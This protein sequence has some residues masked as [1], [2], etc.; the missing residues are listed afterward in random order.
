MHDDAN[1]GV[2]LQ[3]IDPAYEDIGDPSSHA[4]V[5][6]ARYSLQE[7]TLDRWNGTTW[8]L[9]AHSP[10]SGTT[11][12]LFGSWMPVPQTPT[13]T[14]PKPGQTKL[15]VWSKSPFD[16]TRATGS[17][18]EEWVSDALPDYPCIPL[19]LSA[20]TCFGFESLAPGTQVKSPWTHHGPPDITLS[21]GFGPAT[22]DLIHVVTGAN[23]FDIPVLCFPAEAAGRGVQITSSEPGGRSASCSL[24]PSRTRW[25]PG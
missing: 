12:P 17:S 19:L 15:L 16:F 10:K 5:A 4:V 7:L 14:P 13:G 6:K 8:Q 25:W 24:L 1:V 18:W 22:V 2:N 9:V 20:E 3:P 21:W 11:P 23:R